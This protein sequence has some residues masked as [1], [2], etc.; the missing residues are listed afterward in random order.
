M[1]NNSSAALRCEDTS[2]TSLSKPFLE[3]FDLPKA[4]SVGHLCADSAAIDPPA[5]EARR[6]LPTPPYC[7]AS[8]GVFCF[9]EQAGIGVYASSQHRSPERV[10]VVDASASVSPPFAVNVSDLD[11][12]GV[13]ARLVRTAGQ[14]TRTNI[15]ASSRNRVGDYQSISISCLLLL[16][17]LW[18]CGQR[19]CV[20]HHVHGVAARLH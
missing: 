4:H 20:V 5:A 7:R 8:R 14:A 19:A 3:T 1:T 9:D 12:L 2:S 10:A 15:C 16:L 13:L 17:T 6:E 11:N 18:A